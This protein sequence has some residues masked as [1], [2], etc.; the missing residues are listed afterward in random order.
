MLH[1]RSAS[2][3]VQSG[4]ACLL[5]GGPAAF[6]HIK[7]RQLERPPVLVALAELAAFLARMPDQREPVTRALEAISSR[8][9]DWAGFAL[10]RTRI[11]GIVNTTPDSFS[12]G[13]RFLDPERAIEH[14]RALLETGADAIDVGG[15]STRPGAEP[16]GVEEELRRV[17][18]VIRALAD[19]GAT[20][21][22]DTRHAAVMA[23]ALAA[24]ARIV[25][26]VTALAGDPESLALVSRS[27]A[28]VVLMHMQG[29]PATMQRDPRY[30]D[31]VLDVCDFLEARIAACERAGIARS[32]L[33]VDPGI[34]FGKTLAH[35]LDL[36]AHLG[37]LHG[38][39]VGVMLG[40]S[41]KGFIARAS[42]GE[43]PER[44][45]GGSL[46]AAVAAMDQGV[47]WLRV[48]DVA[49]TRQAVALKRQIESA[50]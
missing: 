3:L 20:V 40:V 4:S 31:T 14:G 48:H 46:A 1:G 42:R 50:S 2:L 27:D 29:E 38:L 37:A 8:R 28:A 13:G 12:D 25:N 22:V 19:T 5:A 30:E 7:I 33:L 34:G 36:L 18:P 23:A 41:R 44:R 11:M 21:S 35:N 10:D 26:D 49:E 39:G 45:L 6:T 47:Q 32:R 9:P 43:T 16:A 15:E 17:L 24:G